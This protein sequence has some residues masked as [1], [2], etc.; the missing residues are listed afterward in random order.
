MGILTIS[1]IAAEPPDHRPG[2]MRCDG[3]P[4]KPQ[5]PSHEQNP[6]P[7]PELESKCLINFWLCY[8]EEEPPSQGVPPKAAPP[9]APPGACLRDHSCSGSAE[10]P[11]TPGPS[12]RNALTHKP[13]RPAPFTGLTT[14]A[15]WV[16]FEGTLRKPP[17]QMWPLHGGLSSSPRA[18]SYSELGPSPPNPPRFTARAEALPSLPHRERRL[19]CEG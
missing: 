1:V 6:A 18:E 12:T 13:T 5:P 3:T 10:T 17:T 14:H 4:W 11:P 7:N 16:G 19:Q 2:S 15:P 8:L 9:R